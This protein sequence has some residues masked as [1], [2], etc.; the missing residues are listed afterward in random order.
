[1]L[2]TIG[3]TFCF[4]VA[5]YGQDCSQF[6]KAASYPLSCDLHFKAANRELVF[7]KPSFAL[8][9]LCLPLWCLYT[10]TIILLD[11]FTMLTTFSPYFFLHTSFTT[12]LTFVCWI[13]LGKPVLGILPSTKLWLF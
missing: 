10:C 8:T 11:S 12:A 1:M 3:L 9:L 6:L 4:H 13:E 2:I 5:F 7:R